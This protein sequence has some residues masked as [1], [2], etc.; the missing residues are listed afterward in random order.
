MA[1]DGAGNYTNPYPDF[2]AGTTISSSNVD[3]NNSDIATALTQSIAVDGQSVI[4]ANIPMATYKITGLGVGSALTDSLTLGQAQNQAYIWCGT[5]TGTADAGVLTPSPAITAYAAGQVFRWKAS[6]NVNTGA[7]TIAISGLSTIAAQDDQAALSAGDHEANGIYEGVL[8]TTS[9]IQISKI[10]NGGTGDMLKSE[11]LSG[12]AD[13]PT[14]LS[15]IGGI[16][17]ATTDSLTNKTYDANGTGNVLSNVDIGNAIAASQAE[18]EAGTDNTKLVTSLRVAQAIA[19]LAAGGITL[20]TEQSTASGTSVTFGSIPAGTKRI[21]INLVGVGFST[22][23]DLVTRIGDAGGIENT[24][25]TSTGTVASAGP[26][27]SAPAG[28]T[29]EFNV[30]MITGGGGALHGTITLT[31]EDSSDFTWTATW[32]CLES[33]T[34]Q[35]WGSGSK[36]LSAELT[37]LELSGGTFDGGVVNITYEG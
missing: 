23:N 16:G 27:L 35:S 28:S 5:M 19:A 3:A 17:A 14:A 8:D 31:L 18:A 32:T 26:T 7:M 29:T 36:S 20:G 24:G 37:Q 30:R 4:T 10:A 33:T 21:T 34:V 11:N 1:R 13:D 22:S 6:A 2:V 15:N 25:Y 12:L 9:T